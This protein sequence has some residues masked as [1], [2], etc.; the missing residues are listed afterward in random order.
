MPQAVLCRR[1]TLCKQVV[2]RPS[3]YQVCA[4]PDCSLPSLPVSEACT[5][6]Q[7]SAARERRERDLCARLTV[8]EMRHRQSPY[9]YPSFVTRATRDMGAVQTTRRSPSWQTYTQAHVCRWCHTCSVLRT[10]VRYVVRGCRGC[11]D[12]T[13]ATSRAD[14]ASSYPYERAWPDKQYIRNDHARHKAYYTYTACSLHGS[15]HERLPA[16][17][18]G[19]VQER[20]LGAP[21]E[22]ASVLVRG[23]QSPQG[24]LRR[25]ATTNRHSRLSEF[26]PALCMRPALAPHSV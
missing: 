25:D 6:R 13:H 2:V 12:H 8:L 18:R 22:A 16:D 10:A 20:A 14:M 3:Q 24:Y 7:Y 26:L 15:L 23:C 1:H 9:A 4:G 17:A 19:G 5:Y 21:L 11:A